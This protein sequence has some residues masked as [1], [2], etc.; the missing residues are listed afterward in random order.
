MQELLEQ[1]E[2]VKKRIKKPKKAV[3]TGGMPYANAPLHIGHLAG[4]H[5]PADVYARFMRMMIGEENVLFVCGTDDHGSNSAVSARKEGKGTKDFIDEIYQGQKRT[6]KNYGISL[7][8]FS[9]TSRD[10]NKKYHVEICQDILKKL[11]QNKMIETKTSKQWYD[12]DLKMFLPDR[13]VFGECPKCHDPKAYSEDC[14]VCGANYNPVELLNPKSTVSDSKPELR[15]TDHW[16][17]D[18]WKVADQL[19]PWI[20]SKQKTWRKNVFLET[21]NT[22]TPSFSFSNKSE[23]LFKSLK[24]NLPDHKSRYAPGKLIEV[25]FDNLLDL[26]E[27]RKI[28]LKNNIEIKVNKDWSTRSITR[29]V[30]WGI[31]VPVEIDEKMKGKTFYVWP[32][33]L[34]APLAFTKVALEQ[35]GM[36]PESYMDFWYSKGSQ[37]YQFIGQDNIY[38][39]VLMQ[40]AMWLGTQ[41][42]V[43]R[44]PEEGELQLTDVFA[45]FHLQVNGEKMSKSRG[46][47]I[48]ADELLDEMKY[49]SDQVRYFLSLLSL[50]EKNSNFDFETFKKRNDFLSG[51]LNAA[52]EKPISA[53]HSK[54]DGKI[55]SG[56]LIGKT[57]KETYKIIQNYLR[58]M[59]KA[60][61]SKILF[62]IENYAR[63]INSLFTQ[64]KPHD[65]RFDLEQ[66]QD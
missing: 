60:D 28:F 30:D 33:S 40:G 39:Y 54:F 63:I 10:E 18:M 13:F 4:A 41:S 52:F 35:K 5:V 53:V 25:L 62:M 14:D 15:D 29:D 6:F 56:K 27:A 45:N 17:L 9:G 66:R 34:V 59:E 47:F 43:D 24:E 64:F 16:Y 50:P 11:H 32:E 23:S 1:I 42:K 2:V 22:V 12:P 57:K 21:L 20:E 26:E 58:F 36:D 49:E 19:K 55:P 48:Q 38:F 44:L 7:D 8:T 3:V 46:N 61:Y 31:P 51:P 37:A 65:D